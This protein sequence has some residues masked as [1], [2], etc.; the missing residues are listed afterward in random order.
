MIGGRGTGP[1]ANFGELPFRDC[2]ET[3]DRLHF[4]VPRACTTRVKVSFSAPRASKRRA[5]QP[6]RLRGPTR[7]CEEDASLP[8]FIGDSLSS[9]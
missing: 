8:Q 9:A 1:T 2:L 6:V 5:M 7:R 3:P 4:V